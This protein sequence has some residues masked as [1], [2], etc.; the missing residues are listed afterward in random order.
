MHSYIALLGHHPAISIAELSALLPDMTIEA[1][2]QQYVR[3]STKTEIDQAWLQTIGGTI[4]IAKRVISDAVTLQNVPEILRTE[5]DGLKGKVV[6][7]LRFIGIAPKQSQLLY[8]ACKDG[9]KAK[10][11]SSRY[12]GNE[13]EAAKPIQLHD[14]GILDPKQGCELLVLQEK[15][16]LWIGRTVAAQD[17]KEYTRRDMEK[18]VRDTRAGLLPPKLAQILINLGL[19]TSKSLTKKNQ[20]ILIFDPFCGTGVI[21]IES[22]V[23]GFSVLAS[24]L[25]DTAV[26]GCTGNVEWV[27]KTYKIL[28]KDTDATVWKQDA[29]KAFELKVKPTV[30]VTEGT[31]GPALKSRPTVKD[32]ET[33]ARDAE[34]LAAAF[35]ENCSKTL[36]DVSIVMTLPV[37]YAQ[38]RMIWL[39]KIW[40]RSD[41]LG[42]KPVLP[43]HTDPS[44]PGR[45]SLL[46]RRSDQVVGREIVMFVRR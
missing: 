31:L 30:I 4:L 26:R 21:P 28:K 38:K 24:D 18:P 7:S 23:R 5:L 1:K 17:V 33:Y 12:I 45:F 35:L 22:M 43:P 29:K 34:E 41:E 42:Y 3:F 6:F 10:G 46:Y 15:D 27:R 2:T 11:M 40:K 16:G 37:W 32:A 39:Q 8:R 25:S 9:L 19:F 20:D 13:R 44:A 36:P 14:E